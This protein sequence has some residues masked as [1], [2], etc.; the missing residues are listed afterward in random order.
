MLLIQSKLINLI[1]GIKYDRAFPPPKLVI[2][3]PMSDENSR[4]LNQSGVFTRIMADFDIEEWISR[5]CKDV[6][7]VILY[8]F[9]IPD[10]EREIIIR[11][12][13]KMNINHRSLFPDLYGASE[14]CN[15]CLYYDKY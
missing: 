6:S 7:E 12:L 4:L 11:S 14:Y 9:K 15:T 10:I 3:T 8:K 1:E 5:F 2:Y 13:N